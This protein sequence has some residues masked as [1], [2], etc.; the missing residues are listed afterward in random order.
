MEKAQ[1]RKEI[2]TVEMNLGVSVDL[3]ASKNK[4]RIDYIKSP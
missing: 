2:A 1:N 3:G 4:N